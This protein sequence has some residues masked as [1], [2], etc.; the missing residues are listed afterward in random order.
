MHDNPTRNDNEEEMIALLRTL[1]VEATREDHF[2]ERFVCDFHERMAREAV[3]RPA[4]R[5][6]W[7]HLVHAVR[8]VLRPR[9]LL[10]GSAAVGVPAL[11]AVVAL[12]ATGSGENPAANSVTQEYLVSVDA[13]PVEVSPFVEETAPEPVPVHVDGVVTKAAQPLRNRSVKRRKTYPGAA[14]AMMARTDV[15]NEKLVIVDG[16]AHTSMEMQP[17][18]KTYAELLDVIR[19]A[20]YPAYRLDLAEESELHLQD[21]ADIYRY[22]YSID[23]EEEIEDM[24]LRI[25][26]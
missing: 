14:R 9:R 7:E 3:C 5:L 15:S 10:W 25:T 26:Q 24:P 4:R 2:E 21:D 16:V 19:S 22:Y 8:N 12:L 20:E 6:F 17:R 11:A 13:M 18:K 23:A 1:R